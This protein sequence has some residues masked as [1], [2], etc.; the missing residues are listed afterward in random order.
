M[1]ESCCVNVDYTYM[2]TMI[3]M[4]GICYPHESKKLQLQIQGVR[5]RFLGWY[6]NW[7]TERLEQVFSVYR[8]SS[9]LSF[10][11]SRLRSLYERTCL[12]LE[13]M[14][15]FIIFYHLSIE[16]FWCCRAH[17]CSGTTIEESR[18]FSDQG[19]I[20]Q[21]LRQ[22]LWIRQYDYLTT[23]VQSQI[24]F[25]FIIWELFEFLSTLKR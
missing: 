20:G 23:Q 9:F 14:R 5:G 12:G 2:A 18:H 24:H 13:G 4:L 10:F 8:T 3:E 22:G 11:H 19:S 15:R 16:L 25:I 7:C 17:R 1:L 21:G 6:R